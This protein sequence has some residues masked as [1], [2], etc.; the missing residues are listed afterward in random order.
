MRLVI[1]RNKI[2]HIFTVFYTKNILPQHICSHIYIWLNFI[3][4]YMLEMIFRTHNQ[5]LDSWRYK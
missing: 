1:D 5:L 2:F 3:V 4:I